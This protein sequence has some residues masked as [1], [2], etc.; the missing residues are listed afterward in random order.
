M[1]LSDRLHKFAG[2]VL[3]C[4]G[5]HSA[6]SFNGFVK[7]LLPELM[8]ECA[9]A[10]EVVVDGTVHVLRLNNFSLQNPHSR[11]RDETLRP[12]QPWEALARKI[13]YDG[14]VMAGQVT[15]SQHRTSAEGTLCKHVADVQ[16]DPTPLKPAL[17]VRDVPLYWI[18]V[19]VGSDVC[20]T[21]ASPLDGHNSPF[22]PGGVFITRGHER[23]IPSK[24]KAR[25]NQPTFTV[26]KGSK[27]RGKVVAEVRSSHPGRHRS[28]ST[29][30]VKLSDG[31]LQLDV[32]FLQENGVTLPQVLRI[33]GAERSDAEALF[34][35]QGDP[36][37]TE[38]MRAQLESDCWQHEP[39]ALLR[40]V[41]RRASSSTDEAAAI[42]ETERGIFN[43]FI[44]HCGPTSE[45]SNVLSRIVFLS[46]LYQE[47][48]RVSVGESQPTDKD[49]FRQKKFTACGELLVQQLRLH[50]RNRQ[51]KGRILSDMA[52]ACATHGGMREK[53]IRE[54]LDVAFTSVTTS[55]HT[56]FS[57]G[58]WGTSN[59]VSLQATVQLLGCTNAAA[60]LAMST[61]TNSSSNMKDSK[62]TEPRLFH[63]SS[64]GRCCP[65]DTPEGGNCGLT[66]NT[67]LGCVLRPYMPWD[68]PRELVSALVSPLGEH[69][70]VVFVDFAPVGSVADPQWLVDTLREQRRTCT[71]SPYITVYMDNYYGQHRECYNVHIETDCG[72]PLCMLLDVG[73]YQ[74]G[75]PVPDNMTPEKT[76]WYAISTG[77]VQFVSKSEEKDY[78]IA[79]RPEDIEGDTTHLMIGEEFFMSA[80]SSTV[81][82][83]NHTQAPRLLYYRSMLQGA[84]GPLLEHSLMRFDV[85]ALYLC[86]PQMPLVT[87]RAFRHSLFNHSPI[88]MNVRMLI[89]TF[90]GWNQE[91][92]IVCNRASVE[93]GMFQTLITATVSTE[94]YL[95]GDV[96]IITFPPPEAVHRKE[97][98]CYHAIIKEG[99]EGVGLPRRGSVIKYGDV[100][101]G[102]VL[103]TKGGV[104]DTS[105][106]YHGT[107]EMQ[108]YRVLR[109]KNPERVTCVNV[110]L[111]RLH[112][113]CV[114]DK[115]TSRHGK[116]PL[117]NHL[118]FFSVVTPVL[119]VRRESVRQCV[120]VRTCRSVTPEPFQISL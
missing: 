76:L 97:E 64:F 102:K 61:I 105:E 26:V 110:E 14:C 16:Y 25:N 87:T 9:N 101:I 29:L 94:E 99:E 2:T 57:K 10:Y 113:F 95:Q 89:G 106:V 59:A 100:V 79:A 20:N 11:E 86:Y 45:H 115:A 54:M 73:A 41:A 15:Y 12:I 72:V 112:Q 52:T 114:G 37:L 53:H 65:F 120:T 44:P 40:M 90:A 8:H 70:S 7:W 66:K 96:S 42:K 107:E 22:N 46:H 38:T 116:N 91:D 77:A 84:A 88:T 36:A 17:E 67:A 62:M 118:E 82:F 108:V 98:H 68:V 71:I 35:A 31:R 111:V 13:H 32:P 55:L 85:R 50:I 60:S 48:Y 81:P 117:P 58:Q 28:T 39:M 119:Q 80:T 51:C 19:C 21:W 47:M 78:L 34:I 4:K 5:T 104:Q 69:Q 18:P 1:T 27:G 56:A 103:R 33:M 92:A 109:S 63:S 43:E 74:R 93:R 24:E 23:H 30:H 6:L 83:S 75:L 49:N 3:E